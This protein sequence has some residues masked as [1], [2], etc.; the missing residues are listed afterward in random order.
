MGVT[1]VQFY[2]DGKLYGST[3]TAPYKMGWNSALG[4]DGT[5][6]LAVTAYDAAGHSTTSNTSF[7]VDNTAPTGSCGVSANRGSVSLL[8]NAA[9]NLTGVAKVTFYLDGALYGSTT[10]SPYKMGWNSTHGAD[11]SH[12][13]YAVITDGA[14]NTA[15]TA[16]AAF[17]ID[18]TAPTGSCAE[19]GTG[20][21]VSFTATAA[22]NIGVAKVVFYLDGSVYG[23]KTAAPYKMGWNSTLGANG[24]HS[25]YA[26][27]SDAAGN[28]TTT[29]SFPF[30]ISN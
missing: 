19:S 5:H 3:A 15:T 12:N 11:G 7:T 26:V 21:I 22:D 28:A 9:D 23:T 1:T 4:S 30:I 16:T 29:A 24:S 18:N 2:L 14:G 10:T 20:G 17:N 27:I 6:S 25:V 8:S 13:L